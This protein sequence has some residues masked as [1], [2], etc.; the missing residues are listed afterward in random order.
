MRPP[1]TFSHNLQPRLEISPR[2]CAGPSAAAVGDER[3]SLSGELVTAQHT[4][5]LLPDPHH[6]AHGHHLSTHVLIVMCQ[7]P[8]VMLCMQEVGMKSLQASER[9]ADLAPIR[10]N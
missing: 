10:F 5:I 3:V 7:A 1:F 2:T 4:A 6:V 9:P 8:Q